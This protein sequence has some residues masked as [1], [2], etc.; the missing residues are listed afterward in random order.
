MYV[1]ASG[2][3]VF[4]ADGEFC[5]Y[6]GTGT[7]VTAITRA[8]RAEASLRAAQA[9]L[10]HM[11]RVTTLDHLT[12]SIAHEVKQPIAGALINAQTALRSLNRQPPDLGRATLA[13]DRVMRDAMRAS[14]IVTRTSALV[15]KAPPR[16]DDLEIN[17]LISE[18]VALIRG[19]VSKNGVAL[20]IGLRRVCRS[21]EVIAS[22]FNR[23]C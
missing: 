5:G 1:K 17:E 18:V 14:D 22:S 13:I 15:R 2:K 23:S 16:K 12:A 11:S 9:E 20:Q 21:F 6:R 4:D 8:E 19:E 10:A 3:P 7:D